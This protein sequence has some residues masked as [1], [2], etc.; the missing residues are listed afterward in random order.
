MAAKIISEKK[1]PKLIDL[2]KERYQVFAPQKRGEEVVFA[3]IS[4]VS[5]LALNYQTTL[6]PPKSYLLPP[7]EELFTVKKGRV[8]ETSPP[9]PFVIFGL[10][11][12]DLAGICRLDEIM[13]QEPA[14]SFYLKLRRKA[15]LIAVSDREVGIPPGGDLVL[16]K[17]GDL[18]RTMPLTKNGHRI[19]NLPVFKEKTPK[20]KPQSKDKPTKLEE[21][22][23]DSELLARAI[24]WSRE[25]YPQIWE[26]LGKICL[27]C[28]I[29][30]YVCPLCYCFTMEDTT[31]LD[32]SI[33]T[34]CRNWDACTLPGFATIAGGHNFRQ[35]VK[36]RYYNWYHH[37]FVRAYKEFGRA[38]CVAC[39]RCQKY[40]PAG[41][42][43]EKVLEEVV[44]EFQKAHPVREF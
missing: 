30:T 20:G 16:E 29:C 9:K 23:L 12:E 21:M 27:G 40:C 32:G 37:K 11:L 4:D 13:S 18:Y 35:T 44:T 28:G 39:G 22:L 26:R 8:T 36:D 24:E 2:L 3:L 33:C 1:I 15:I 14:D 25:D 19:I 41:I 38:Q 7:E 17:V 34:R 10:N 5:K 31:S 42:D 6:L 43:I